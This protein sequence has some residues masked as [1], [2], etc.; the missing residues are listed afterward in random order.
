[1]FSGSIHA[2]LSEDVYDAMMDLFEM[3]WKGA[4]KELKQEHLE[5]FNRLCKPKSPDFI[6]RYRDYYAFF[7]Y[8]MFWGEVPV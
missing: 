8:S 2:P 5:K 3:R 4:E 1:M 7:T 6:L